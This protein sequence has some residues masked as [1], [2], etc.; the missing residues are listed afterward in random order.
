MTDIDQQTMKMMF[1]MLNDL[2]IVL[3]LDDKIM[4]QS[5]ARAMGLMQLASEGNPIALDLD[6]R[7]ETSL[8]NMK[9]SV[10]ELLREHAASDAVN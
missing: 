4:D 6:E 5:Y 3:G 1:F 10:E 8:A 9:Q 7:T 2:Q